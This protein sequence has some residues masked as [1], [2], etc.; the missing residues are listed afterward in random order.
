MS[1]D[2]KE[3]CP[4][5]LI[6]PMGCIQGE[7]VHEGGR[8]RVVVYPWPPSFLDEPCIVLAVAHPH[9]GTRIK[10][11]D[12][13]EWLYVVS[14]QTMGWIATDIATCDVLSRHDTERSD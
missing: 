6:Q 3:I 2:K 12:Y 7:M 14:H 8:L 10:G 11:C 5:D 4:G 9:D 13:S 1:G